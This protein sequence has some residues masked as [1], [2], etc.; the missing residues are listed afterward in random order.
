MTTDVWGVLRPSATGVTVRFERQYATTSD[1]LWSSVTEPDRLARWLGPVYGDL[2]V[3]GRY[4]LRMGDDVDGSPENAVGEVLECDPPHRL[5]VGWRFPGEDESRVALEIRAD[6]D[7]AVLV[8]EHLDLAE[9]AARGYGGGWHASL[10][11]LDDY[12]AGR[13]VRPW[14]E[15]F[16]AALPRYQEA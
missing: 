5:L 10:D 8:L 4:E 16:D 7:G 3:G 1:D 14:Q 9:A 15:L 13:P 11:Q 2:R 6:G 12:A